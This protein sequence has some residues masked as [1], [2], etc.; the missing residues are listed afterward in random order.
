MVKN[1]P[2]AHVTT[3]T[4]RQPAW[5]ITPT[6]VAT[7]R[8]STRPQQFARQIAAAKTTGHAQQPKASSTPHL[9]ALKTKP[10]DHA[11]STGPAHAAA[12]KI[13][14]DGAPELVVKGPGNG[15]GQSDSGSTLKFKPADT[16]ELTL[17][18][19]AAETDHLRARV[20]T[21][22]FRAD[23]RGLAF[24]QARSVLSSANHPIEDVGAI[25]QPMGSL[26]KDDLGVAVKLTY[27]DG[28]I[29]AQR[30]AAATP[31]AI[32][33]PKPPPIAG[34]V[35]RHTGESRTRAGSTPGFAGSADAE[36]EGAE[37]QGSALHSDLRVF[38]NGA[39]QGDSGSDQ[40]GFSTLEYRPGVDTPEFILAQAQTQTPEQVLQRRLRTMVETG[41]FGAGDARAFARSQAES[42]PSMAYNIVWARDIG[43][44]GRLIAALPD[45]PAGAAVKH[46][47]AEE[48]LAGAQR[49]AAAVASGNAPTNFIVRAAADDQRI[50]TLNAL[51]QNVTRL[52]TGFSDSDNERFFSQLHSAAAQLTGPHAPDQRDILNAYAVQFLGSL[53]DRSRVVAILRGM[54][55]VG[56]NGTIDPNS[57]LARFLESAL[58]GQAQLGIPS[59]ETSTTPFGEAPQGITSLLNAISESSDTKLMAG[60]L[61]AVLQWTRANP[62]QAAILA[63]QDIGSRTP[64][65]PIPHAT[66]YRDA[67]TSLVDNSFNDFILFDPSAP[68]ATLTRT[69][70]ISAMA[71]LQLLTLVVSGPPA[72][73]SVAGRFATVVGTRAG[74]FDA[75][76]FGV[77]SGLD[78][79]RSPIDGLLSA[80]G[81]NDQVTRGVV[82][83]NLF[84]KIVNSYAAGL[85]ESQAGLRA[86]AVGLDLHN[87]KIATDF[88]RAI[89]TGGLFLSAW[90]PVGKAIPFLNIPGGANNR[91]IASVVGR[92]LLFSGSAGAT[93]QNLVQD[94]SEEEAQRAMAQH[95]VNMN[96]TE[97]PAQIVLIQFE[98]RHS[99]INHL[100][101]DSALR[102]AQAME[103][104][105]S[106]AG[107]PTMVSDIRR[108]SGRYNPLEVYRRVKEEYPP[109]GP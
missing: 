63:A 19:V 66:G 23:T 44:I 34:Q 20:A 25:G 4:H 74:Q 42:V 17:A 91:E 5:N 2:P 65:G 78:M 103:D 102:I 24:V 39:D 47:Y 87:V 43:G 26:P 3:I 73:G 46:A 55:S 22:G 27:P 104:G 33:I 97:G 99:A 93:V 98:G 79:R 96:M 90:I 72:D 40:P 52:S 15:A 105:A 16:P 36:A 48:A 51:L 106:F 101:G 60:T 8:P 64:Q 100:P 53:R 13:R 18:K 83:A 59:E 107:A 10:L 50:I 62:R 56:E 35:A 57:G 7:N 32:T 68:G 69:A 85:S 9:A 89:G 21:G 14:Q 6:Y 82:A 67:L 108:V 109:V 28:A 11:P 1:I 76:A 71:D 12:L 61:H 30:L 29:A 49:L 58:R 94:Q 77:A 54:G 86:Q 41:Q 95:M 92:S 84:G 80:N 75:Y 81:E 70:P 88:T 37:A 31:G 45:D 38:G